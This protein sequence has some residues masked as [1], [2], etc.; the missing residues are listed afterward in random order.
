MITEIQRPLVPFHSYKYFKTF[1]VCPTIILFVIANLIISSECISIA[2]AKN[3]NNL[4]EDGLAKR[5]KLELTCY[6]CKATSS[7]N[8][9]TEKFRD[10]IQKSDNSGMQYRCRVYERNGMVVAQGIVPSMLC[11]KEALAKINGKTTDLLLGNGRLFVACCNSDKC[12]T[13]YC[14]AKGEDNT[15]C[16]TTIGWKKP[17]PITASPASLRNEQKTTSQQLIKA[18]EET[19]QIAERGEIMQQFRSMISC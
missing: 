4:G 18:M 17:K 2:Q 3:N 12:N 19:T 11:K 14:Q 6:S 10:K 15:I 5:T 1:F 8:T 16:N 7:N 13:G 9:C